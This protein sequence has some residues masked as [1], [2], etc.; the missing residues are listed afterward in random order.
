MSNHT[1]PERRVAVA[2]PGKGGLGHPQGHIG[3]NAIT[4]MSEAL[5]SLHGAA[6]RD[7]VFRAAGVERHLAAAPTEMVPDEDVAFLHL[8]TVNALG[9]NAA[10]L[11][12]RDAGRRTGAYILANRIP[13]PA[14]PILKI[15]P[16]GWSLLILLKAIASHAWTFAGAGAFSHRVGKGPNPTASLIIKGGPVARYIACDEPVCAYYAATFE[17]ILKALVSSRVTVEEVACEAMGAPAC[18]FEV[19]LG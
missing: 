15:M 7:A 5:L 4:R 16:A 6:V 18:I 1:L 12:G 8:A 9:L 14:Q 13:K 2:K 17:T 10:L 11:V 3:P 19:R